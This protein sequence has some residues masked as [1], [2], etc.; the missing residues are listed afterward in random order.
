M[1]RAGRGPGTLQQVR[2]LGC[3]RDYIGQHCQS[4]EA[5]DQSPVGPPGRTLDGSNSQQLLSESVSGAANSI[6]A[7]ERVS[8]KNAP[9]VITVPSD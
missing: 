7:L 4:L 8:E 1:A 9:P 5:P 2:K 6:S 3:G